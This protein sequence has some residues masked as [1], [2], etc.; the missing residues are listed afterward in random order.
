MPA[1]TITP[2]THPMFS[3]DSSA[4]AIAM[5]D[6]KQDIIP[7][8]VTVDSRYTTFFWAAGGVLLQ[9]V[10]KGHEMLLFRIV[11][12]DKDL[13]K[14]SCSS[15]FRKLGNS[16]SAPS[17]IVFRPQSYWGH[18]ECIFKKQEAFLI[19][20]R[21]KLTFNTSVQ[22]WSDMPKDTGDRVINTMPNRSS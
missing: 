12:M 14:K 18:V 15:N 9:F 10:P 6:S 2:C 7:V 16:P 21:Y 5:Y 20:I 4:S 3:V 11:C 13:S 17:S 22:L 1:Q 8:G 19:I